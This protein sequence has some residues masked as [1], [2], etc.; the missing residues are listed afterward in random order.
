MTFEDIW[1]LTKGISEERTFSRTSSLAFYWAL[2]SLKKEST[3]LEIGCE[4]GRSTSILAQV[5]KE[6][7]HRLY[8]ID[9]FVAEESFFHCTDMLKGVG[10]PFVLF[11]MRN[12]EALRYT[13]PSIDF[14]HVDGDHSAESLM[15]DCQLLSRVTRGGFACF[16]DYGWDVKST[17]DRFI[18]N[19]L[20]ETGET[21]DT[22]HIVKRR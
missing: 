17:V 13:L 4:N 21:S 2:S 5:A 11:K 9:P 16:H 6:N 20:W 3:I 14:I 18:L 22:L 1:E 12:E 10:V 8:L 19:E 15:V 7:Q